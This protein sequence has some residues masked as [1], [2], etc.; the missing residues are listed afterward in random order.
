MEFP[1][2][3]L[4]L[5]LAILALW[6]AT[7][8][9]DAARRLD[10]EVAE[11]RA[12]LRRPGKLAAVAPAPAEAAASPEPTVAAAG[13]PPPQEPRPSD[14]QPPPER[15]SWARAAQARVEPPVA[16]PQAPSPPPVGPPLAP[17]TALPAPPAET[18]PAPPKEPP[19]PPQAQPSTQPPRPSL[20][21]RVG[22]RL[23][24]W[25]GSIALALAGAFLVKYSID[26]GWIGPA[27]RVVLAVLLGL[28]LLGAGEGLRLR[29]GR[30]AAGLAAAGIAVLFAAW[31]AATNLYGLLP[32][33]LGFLLMGATAGLG[34]VLSLRHGLMVALVG[35]V[36][37]FLTPTWIGGESPD[38]RVLFAYLLTLQSGLLAVSR[39]RLWPSLALLSLLAGW[40]WVVVWAFGE[41][42]PGDSTWAGLFL[43][44]SLVAAAVAGEGG[45]RAREGGALSAALSLAVQAGGAVLAM[46][47]VAHRGGYAT[48]D[49]VLVG[50]LL[51]AAYAVARREPGSESLAWL[52]AGMTAALL[53][54]W[55]GGIEASAVPRFLTTGLALGALAAG[56]AYALL[57][58][59]ARPGRWASLA[60][61]AGLAVFLIVWLTAEHR[62]EAPPVRW[63]A[64]ALA[65]AALY[66]A[67]AA[68]VARRRAAGGEPDLTTA[69]AALAAAATA[70]VS[71]AVALELERAWW[72]VAWAL[73]VP[74]LVWLAARLRLRALRGLA[75]ALAAATALRLL[76]NPA[77]LGYP[78]GTLPV[79]NWLLYGYGVPLASM[80]LAARFARRDPA[81]G[82]GQL[83]PALEGLALA[84]AFALV[85]LH[86]RQLFHPGD[87]RGAAPDLHEWTAY[88]VAWQLLGV[89][90]LAWRPRQGATGGRTVGAHACLGLGLAAA[91]VMAGLIES[92][93]WNH[94]AVGSL[95]VLNR[96]LWFY[97]APALLAG[98]AAALLAR[99]GARG[100]ANA[101]AAGGLLLLSLLVTLE[102]ARTYRGTH[103]D[104]G[105]PGFA[106]WGGFT[107]AWLALAVLLQL[108]RSRVGLGIVPVW[109]H[110]L[111][112]LGL[113]S[114]LLVSGLFR[115]PLVTHV[116]V[117][118]WPVVN[119]LLWVYGAPALLAGVAAALLARRGER[120]AADLIAT[121]ALVLLSLLVT[122]E[123]AQAH[124]GR[125]L[126][127][128]LPS[129]AEWG[130]FTVGW[131]ALGLIS[132]VA[133]RRLEVPGAAAW[134]WLLAAAGLGSALLVSGWLRNPL[135]THVDVGP[136]PV[137]NSLLWVYGVPALLAALGARLMARL[138]APRA[139]R[140]ASVGALLLGF[141]LVTLEVAQS[142]RGP[143]LDDGWSGAAERYAWSAAWLV[144]GTG[145]LLA[146]I[147]RRAIWLRWASLA[148]M[149]LTVFKV[150]LY[151]TTNLTDLYRV[152]SFLGLGVSLLLLAFLY[153]RFVFRETG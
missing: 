153:Q 42:A 113:V 49:W 3:L 12:E 33:L 93:L 48:A 37:G 139:A 85:T 38:A 60:A 71:L 105:L 10:D 133:T 103:L 6:R 62:L 15:P 129:F 115:S 89:G 70:F 138:G 23:T 17:R 20:E 41:P 19:T 108:A 5:I 107:V 25:V 122:L 123:V 36:G 24:V 11:L 67:A 44:G 58:G 74:A 59:A 27:A 145:L 83:G 110:G 52:A 135:W 116:D 56:F 8:S 57:W 77:V 35:L 146:G 143:Y 98:V 22:A 120:A 94:V 14:T 18:R 75:G 134:S 132:I 30:I 112:A 141:T 150:F 40:A 92:P 64:W 136:L 100:A 69:L 4:A 151:D 72:S 99:R 43:L 66:A 104:T 131:L 39:R 55:G 119:L 127:T 114:A 106:E 147:A 152:L 121:G 1:F 137:A 125:Y 81:R 76:A 68:P 148:V 51:V 82:A 47:L 9:Q 65:L 80:A 21:Q 2:S 88:S 84:F 101:L 86:V 45:G 144:V 32:P 34:V 46:A 50:L 102:V 126:D 95:P 63:S 29:L 28:A 78:I 109:A 79:W 54:L 118:A 26:Q 87:L 91:L 61:A 111:T 13:Q 149:T 96:L 130:S 124:R 7:R 16:A 97:G 117:G 31:L 53:A 90:L 140:L 73:E 142:Y 128:G